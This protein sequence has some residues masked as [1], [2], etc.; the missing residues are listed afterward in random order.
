MMA[1]KE[2]IR[3]SIERELHMRVFSSIR[4]DIS[5]GTFCNDNSWIILCRRYVCTDSGNQAKAK[6][7]CGERREYSLIH[8]IPH[9]SLTQNSLGSQIPVSLFTAGYASVTEKRRFFAR[10]S[11]DFH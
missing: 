6:Y 3:V 11:Q 5:S 4:C 1:A 10:F 7:N 9:S 2:A 8:A